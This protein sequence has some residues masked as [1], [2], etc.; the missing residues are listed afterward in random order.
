M[1]KNMKHNLEDVDLSYPLWTYSHLKH[2][3]WKMNFLFGALPGAM[4][5]LGN[6]ILLFQVPGAKFDL[7]QREIFECFG[8]NEVP[9]PVETSDLFIE[10]TNRTDH[11]PFCLFLI[12]PGSQ[13]DFQHGLQYQL[14]ETGSDFISWLFHTCSSLFASQCVLA[15]APK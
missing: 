10:S 8:G 14:F 2:W 4:L 5:V 7:R 11:N 12:L 13:R 6:V 1:R 3:I 9:G 15:N